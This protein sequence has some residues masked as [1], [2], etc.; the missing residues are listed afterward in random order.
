MGLLGRRRE[1]G[2]GEEEGGGGRRRRTPSS[3][4][5]VDADADAGAATAPVGVGGGGGG[6]GEEG[7][8]V[9]GLMGQDGTVRQQDQGARAEVPWLKRKGFRSGHQY[10]ES[11][12][13]IGRAAERAQVPVPEK[14]RGD[15]LW[16]SGKQDARSARMK[17]KRAL[18]SRG[19]KGSRK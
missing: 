3:D 8:E 18:G 4:V 12:W 16:A 6:D 11:N 1:V 15:R 7:V 5:D 10:R 17:G 9:G 14:K 19:K 2:R 13:Y